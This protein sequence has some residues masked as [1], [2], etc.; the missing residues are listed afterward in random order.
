MPADGSVRLFVIVEA[1]DLSISDL[2]NIPANHLRHAKSSWKNYELSDHDFPLNPRGQ[3]D[4][5]NVGKRLRNED[6]IPD[7]ILSST[8]KRACQTAVESCR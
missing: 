2:E 5:S 7:A 3:R 4:A 6:L 1:L 8:A